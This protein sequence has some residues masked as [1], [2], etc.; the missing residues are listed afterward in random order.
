MYE[1]MSTENMMLLGAIAQ[2]T[3]AANPPKIEE[4]QRA[5]EGCAELYRHAAERLGEDPPNYKEAA[6]IIL[7]AVD[8]ASKIQHECVLAYAM[9]GQAG[10]DFLNNVRSAFQEMVNPEEDG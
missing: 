10:D 6:R 3:Y 8:A 9:S 1:K 4:M 5:L 2:E 7:I